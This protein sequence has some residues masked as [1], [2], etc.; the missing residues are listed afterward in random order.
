MAERPIDDGLRALRALHDRLWDPHAELVRVAPG[1]NPGVDL[2]VWQLHGVRETALGAVVDLRHGHVA[3]AAAG[4]RRVLANQYREPAVPWSGTFKVCA[5]EPHPPAHAQE[6]FHYDPNWRQF[7]GCILAYTL[8]RHGADLPQDLGTAIEDAI[9]R[10]VRGEPRDRIP[11]WYTNPNL[12]H[13]WL[14]SWIGV[15][16]HEPERIRDGETR[17]GRIMERLER[18]GDVDEYNSPTYDG[19]DLFAA[20]LW[21]SMPPT[22]RFEEAGTDLA[23]RVGARLGCLYHPGL[24]AIC[25]P[26]GRAYGM[27]LTRYVSLAGQWLALA[28]ADPS[29]VL[30]PRLDEHTVHVHD[31]Y[32]LEIFDD[33]SDTVVQH[34]PIADVD[35]PRRHEQRFDKVVAVSSLDETCAVGAERGRVA[36]FA[37]DQYVPFTAHFLDDDTV[38]AV[39]VKLGDATSTVDVQVDDAQTATLVAHG[40]DG[41]VELVLILSSEPTVTGPEVRLGGFVV[42]FSAAPSTVL[43]D[44]KPAGT[45]LR[46]SFDLAT[47]TMT[48]HRTSRR[49]LT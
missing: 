9:G 35:T 23:A 20:A 34:I 4:L 2:S 10:C 27:L 25:G 18:N 8:E 36:T 30:P 12:M 24:G 26:Y 19:I 29:R 43:T 31:L 40:A 7:L 14:E 41:V 46:V 1:V 38:A 48:A 37:K 16:A 3:R 13:A 6:W 32:F 28:G 42:T 5:E 33:L 15:R 21:V 44:V 11:D 47:V 17:L 45:E 39:G 49:S 22:P